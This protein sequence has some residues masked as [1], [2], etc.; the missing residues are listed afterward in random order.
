MEL[1]K[2]AC[3]A[4]A[5]VSP[6]SRVVNSVG[7]VMLV[8]MMLLTVADV[9]L[10]YLFRMPILGSLEITRF[11]LVSL[12]FLAMAYTQVKKGH[13]RLDTIFDRLPRKTQAL[14]DSIAYLFSIGLVSLT[15][16]QSIVYAQYMWTQGIVSEALRIPVYPFVLIVA[17]GSLLLCLV[18]VADFIN[19]ID[20]VITGKKWIVQSGLIL[21]TLLFVGL[22]ISAPIW[23]HFLPWEITRDTIAYIG[24][25]M[26]IFLLFAGM[27]CGF[28][29][30]LVGLLAIVLMTGLDAGLSRLGAVPYTNA[31][32]YD[33]CVIPLF[34]LMGSFTF[35][36]GLSEDLYQAAYKWLGNL[37]GGLAMATVGGCA[38]FAA[39]CGSSLATAVTMGRVALPEMRKYKYDQGLATGCIAA[40]GAIG[41]LIPPS[42]IF[43]L[44]GIL[45]EQSIGKLFLAG[46]I[47]GIMQAAFYMIVIYMICKRNP[48]L[49]PPGPK[50]NIK[51]KIVVLKDTWGVLALFLLVIGGIYGGVFTPTEAAAIGAFG[52]LLFTLG[53]RK[54]K[55]S[56][57][58]S[59]LLETGETTAMAFLLL[60]GA[61]FF[62]YFLV[63]TRIPEQTANF[64]TELSINRYIILLLIVIIY[65]FLGCILASMPMVVLTVPIFYPIIAAMDFDPL[66][67]GVLVVIMVEAGVITPPYGM[68]IFGI[69]AIAK[70]VPIWTIYRGMVPFLM[71]DVI[72]VA[73]LFIFPEI[74]IFLPHLMKGI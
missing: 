70:D 66:W 9:T 55:W 46:V 8:A 48:M 26:L 43:V 69:K 3:K 50:T 17:F 7:M 61:S 44:Y 27:A 15:T 20:R 13:V 35:H 10:R 60:I 14:I 22:F 32:A 57:F 21:L 5:L 59:S 18:L 12:V 58:T 25:G 6:V 62:G 31:S 73:L 29:M 1:S 34:L 30:W 2:L 74:A 11:M 38:G 36:S 53:R 54:I 67:F 28:S 39:V 51:E 33:L 23:L 16:W 45:T 40:G 19:S 56:N 47:P 37:P 42:V 52:A 64:I 68:N 24:M 71:A 49:G 72:E 4:N 63:V 65:L 41:I